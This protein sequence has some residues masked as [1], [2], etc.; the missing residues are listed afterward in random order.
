MKLG[1]SLT[2]VDEWTTRERKQWEE[3]VT[4]RW[5]KQQHLINKYKSWC[6]G[7]ELWSQSRNKVT[8]TVIADKVCM[9]VLNPAILK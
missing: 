5:A 6:D 9:L 8:Q 7:R 4:T 2:I 1:L 3:R